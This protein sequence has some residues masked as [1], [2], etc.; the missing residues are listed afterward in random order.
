MEAPITSIKLHKQVFFALAFVL[1]AVA[2]NSAPQ[3][4][5][6][7]TNVLKPRTTLTISGASTA[8][9][10]MKSLQPAFE[11]DNANYSLQ[12]LE[13]TGTSGNSG[14]I[15]G[16][17][18]KTLDLGLLTRD[19][20]DTQRA[21]GINAVTFGKGSV[22]AFVHPGVNITTLTSQQLT[23]IYAGH[24]S[25]WSQ[26]GGA[27]LPV[28][29][30]IR[31]PD[32]NVTQKLRDAYFGKTPFPSN[33]QLLNNSKDIVTA[34][35]GTAGG[36]GY[37]DWP[38]VVAENSPIKPVALDGVGPTDSTYP[39]TNNLTVAYLKERQSDIQPFTDWL[40]SKRG[41]DELVKLGVI[42]LAAK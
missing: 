18:D 26:V 23:D 33:A 41:Q 28:V 17:G 36:I 7:A 15:K 21:S 27:D 6:T 35:S 8:L 13:S 39:L 30:F 14:A 12:I 37:G 10:I 5:P 40:V 38:A 29:L 16:I 31:Q 34:V 19:L 9:S 42:P 11:A 22:A 1:V 4:T 20:T 3:T 32:E 2:C 25:N 24:V